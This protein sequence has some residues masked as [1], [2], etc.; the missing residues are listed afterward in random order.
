MANWDRQFAARTH[1][2]TF[3]EESER[4]SGDPVG[5]RW[6]WARTHRLEEINISMTAITIS[7][8]KDENFSQNDQTRMPHHHHREMPNRNDESFTLDH[9]YLAWND[10]CDSQIQG[11]ERI[12]AIPLS[13]FRNAKS[14][15]GEGSQRNGS[16][17]IVI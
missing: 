4:P 6:I 13:E 2:H 3:S 10:L 1:K 8:A 11:M 5:H 16:V 15:A 12:E 17:Q 14:G 9:Q 7:E